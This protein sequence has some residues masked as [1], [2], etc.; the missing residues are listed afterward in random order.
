[1]SVRISGLVWEHYPRGGGEFLTA[2]ALADHADHEGHNVRPGIAGL[3]R[4]TRLSQ[5]SIQFHLARMRRDQ[6][7][8]PVRYLHGGHGRATEYRVNPAWI[9]NPAGFAPFASQG[10]PPDTTQPYSSTVQVP[11]GKDEA[12]DDLQCNDIAP[13]P[14]GTVIE[15]TTTAVAPVAEAVVVVGNEWTEIE[16]PPPLQG[17]WLTSARRV[18]RDCPSA[19]RAAVANEVAAIM[20]EGRP[21]GNPIGLLNRLVECSKAGTFVP[22]RGIRYAMKRRQE[23]EARACTLEATDRTATEGLRPVSEIAAQA[24]A[25]MRAALQAKPP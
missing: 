16:V 5:R 11:A 7:L 17:P 15:P 10:S 6:W 12:G 14:S 1:M 22:S 24:L 3:A 18:L 23:A 8:L 4:K 21:R 9:S 2:L 25:K 20:S 19:E 13:Q